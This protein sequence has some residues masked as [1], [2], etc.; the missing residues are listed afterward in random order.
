M[1]EFGS[2]TIEKIKYSLDTNKN[3]LVSLGHELQQNYP[4]CVIKAIEQRM[5]KLRSDYGK[6]DAEYHRRIRVEKRIS[7]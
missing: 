1:N 2:W 3:E 6:C 7:R 4:K 5:A